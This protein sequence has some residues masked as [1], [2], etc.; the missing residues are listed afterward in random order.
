MHFRVFKLRINSRNIHSLIITERRF[1]FCCFVQLNTR[2]NFSATFV[3]ESTTKANAIFSRL[4]IE[5]LFFVLDWLALIASKGLALNCLNRSVLGK[6]TRSRSSRSKKT[7]RRI[8]FSR[9]RHWF[10]FLLSVRTADQFF[11]VF[12]YHDDDDYESLD[13]L[14]DDEEELEE[15]K[16]RREKFLFPWLHMCKDLDAVSDVEED[17]PDTTDPYMS[18][19]LWVFMVIWMYVILYNASVR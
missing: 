17:F 4:P 18:H 7:K 1:E 11:E 19:E 14:V 12:E 2:S 6:R 3:F 16:K 9:A 10:S 15:E 5:T 13:E 8:R